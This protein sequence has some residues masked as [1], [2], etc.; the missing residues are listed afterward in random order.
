MFTKMEKETIRLAG[1][2]ASGRSDII[3]FINNVNDKND[4]FAGAI[5]INK[6]LN[7]NNVKIS[8]SPDGEIYYF[9]I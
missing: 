6:G 5:R 1:N 4:F 8:F 7:A 3:R 9:L 2:E